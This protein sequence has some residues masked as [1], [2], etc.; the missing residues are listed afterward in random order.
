MASCFG[1]SIGSVCFQLLSIPAGAQSFFRFSGVVDAF[2]FLCGRFAVISL[3]LIVLLHWF[4]VGAVSTRL[5]RCAP[6]FIGPIYKM[7]HIHNIFT[8]VTYSLKET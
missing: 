4:F 5:S 8:L 6:F 3:T 7:S 1:F 2:H